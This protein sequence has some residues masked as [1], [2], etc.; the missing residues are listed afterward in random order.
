MAAGVTSNR[1]ETSDMV[2]IAEEWEL[3]GENAD[4]NFRRNGS[5]LDIY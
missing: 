2:K 4:D 1:W 3:V 5:S